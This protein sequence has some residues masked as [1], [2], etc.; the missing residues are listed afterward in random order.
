[1]SS[2][3]SDENSEKTKKDIPYYKKEVKKEKAGKRKLFLS[4]V[5]LAEELK[6]V[7]KNTA[8]LEENAQYR[9]QAWYEG[10]LWRAPQVLPEV[11]RNV[12]DNQRARPR[13]VE[14]KPSDWPGHCQAHVAHAKH[15]HEIE[16]ADPPR[17]TDPGKFLRLCAAGVEAVCGRTRAASA[18][19]TIFGRFHL[20][21]PRV[22]A[23]NATGVCAT[24]DGRAC[25][26]QGAVAGRT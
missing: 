18:A 21:K 2:T 7:R 15:A 1:M 12:A 6:R 25:T 10:G 3:Q 8:G 24:L 16:G 13:D 22:V 20:G 14:K 17:G 23:R 9:N 11:K 5:K 4:L 19:S 26:K